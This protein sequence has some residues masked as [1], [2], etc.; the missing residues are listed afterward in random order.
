MLTMQHPKAEKR[1][2]MN[3]RDV[4]HERTKR[5]SDAYRL[6]DHYDEH[7][8]VPCEEAIRRIVTG[9]VDLFRGARGVAELVT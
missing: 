1:R 6:L 5:L 7:Q 2:V 8:I 4:V 9:L 3:G